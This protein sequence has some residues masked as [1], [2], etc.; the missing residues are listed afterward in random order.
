MSGM[1][2]LR[3][4]VTMRVRGISSQSSLRNFRSQCA[5]SHSLCHGPPACTRSA[6]FATI[7]PSARSGFLEISD[8][9]SASRSHFDLRACAPPG[10]LPLAALGAVDFFIYVEA[11]DFLPSAL[12]KSSRDF[13]EL[14][15]PRPLGMMIAV[16]LITFLC[17]NYA[18][19][20]LYT[21]TATTIGLHN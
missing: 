1:R 18:L 14:R 2:R 7:Q 5:A 10:L 12:P 16:I 20:E 3:I 9:F 4:S 6:N 11:D 13:I 8:V 21:P 15:L 19:Y 17:S